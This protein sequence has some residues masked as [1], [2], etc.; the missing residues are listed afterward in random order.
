[1]KR[2]TYDGLLAVLRQVGIVAGDLLHVQGDICRIGPVEAEDR[3]S[4]V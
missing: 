2:L 1:M 3:K 4:V